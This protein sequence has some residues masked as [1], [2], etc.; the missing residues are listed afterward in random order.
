MTHS[1]LTVST[2]PEVAVPEIV[3][4]LKVWAVSHESISVEWEPPIITNGIITQY[5]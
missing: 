5:R 3:S 1:Q 4:M 2:Q